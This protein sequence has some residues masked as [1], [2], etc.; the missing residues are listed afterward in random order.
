MSSRTT[1]RPHPVLVNGDMSGSLASEPTILQS[2]SRISYALTWADGTDIDGTVSVQVSND[3]KR[4]SDGQ[5]VENAGTWNTLTLAYNGSAT[6]TVPI[7]GDSG[8]G[9]IDVEGTAAYAVR[10]I[11]S[12]TDGEGVLNVVAAGKVS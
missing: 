11:Y 2:L 7:S 6:T 8:N 5:T 1:L 9:F 4:S 3:Y 10:L 12:F